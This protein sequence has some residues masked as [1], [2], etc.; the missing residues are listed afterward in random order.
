MASQ[1]KKVAVVLSG[2]GAKG[3][4][5]IGVLKVIEKAGIPVDIITGTSMGALVGGLYASG[6]NAEQLD[7]MVRVQNWNT[8]FFDKS[9]ASNKSLAERKKQNT[10]FLSKNIAFKNKRLQFGTGL[11]E[12]DNLSVLFSELTS[13]YPDSMSF[14][15][16]PIPFACVATNI[17][18]NSEYD[19][20]SGILAQ[21]M[22]SSM[23]IP[24]VF[25]PVRKDSMILIDGGLRNNFP[26]DVAQNM[27]ADYVIGVTLQEPPKTA[28]Q[29]Q[30]GSSI[31]R[32]I[33]DINCKNKYE[34]N[35]RKTNIHV[36]VNTSGY[37]PASFYPAAIDTLI[38]RGEEE[39]MKHWNELMSLKKELNIPVEQRERKASP[40]L[41]SILPD[42]FRVQKY[43]FNEVDS[44]DRVYVMQK[45][46]LHVGDTIQAHDLTKIEKVM[47]EDL[48]YT[49]VMVSAIPIHYGYQIVVNAKNKKM[50]QLNLGVRFDTE[51]M[52]ALQANGNVHFRTKMPLDME[53]TLRLGK[54]IMG[55]LNATIHPVS[56][57]RMS[58]AYIYR[59]DDINVNVNGKRQFNITYNKHSLEAT[60]FDFNVKNL[61]VRFGAAMDYYNYNNM[62]Q[63]GNDFP[64]INRLSSDLLYSYHAEMNYNSENDWYY[65]TRGTKFAATYGYFTD[66]FA[67][68]NSGPGFSELQAMWR[69]TIALNKRLIIQ[70]MIYGRALFGSEFPVVRRNVIGGPWFGHYSDQQLPFSGVGGVELIEN[71]ITGLQVK[72]QQRIADNNF[73]GTSIT[74]AE[75]SNKISS[76]FNANPTWGIDLGYSYRSMFGPLEAIIGYSGLTQ[77]P[78]FLINLGFEF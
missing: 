30:T 18:D 67:E 52:V 26:V 20:H 17:I 6:Y 78:Y 16:L 37:S 38:R 19:F 69:T 63:G 36:N 43:V 58:L 71:V 34:E 75:K 49:N 64:F 33:I 54:R 47:R 53:A 29:L 48:Y 3:M 74:C 25:S 11:I 72:I 59:H 4:A 23:S 31:I 77:K 70:P 73:I 5:H 45:F 56:F 14:Y 28:E 10:Y 8:L 32:Q 62:L 2:G 60:I 7:S 21:A 22:R 57:G 1:R 76:L 35:L 39:A 24:A 46:N 55:K 61:N 68:Y 50:C 13:Q 65:P 42:R 12:G 41:P 15:D 9:D 27:G 40:H 66:D 44:T 51:E